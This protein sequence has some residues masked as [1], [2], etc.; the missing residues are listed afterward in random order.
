MD[1]TIYDMSSVVISIQLPM[2][3]YAA[4]Q[5]EKEFERIKASWIAIADGGSVIDQGER[6]IQK[7]FN[8][9]VELISKADVSIN[10]YCFL[11]AQKE[12]KPISMCCA[13]GDEFVDGIPYSKIRLTATRTKSR[14]H[15]RRLNRRSKKERLK[16]AK[17]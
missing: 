8:M 17:R 5:L 14:L 15:K 16:T 1:Y 7:P 10:I 3:G 2:Y 9:P 4:M 13:I 12:N 11:K 6:V